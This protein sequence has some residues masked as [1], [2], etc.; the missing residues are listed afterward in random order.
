MGKYI[1]LDVHAT[2]CTLAVIGAQGR[3][4]GE[5][6]QSRPQEQAPSGG[7]VKDVNGPRRP[8]L[9]AGPTRLSSRS[10]RT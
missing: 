1:G 3:K 9:D 5:H 2:S 10:R 7:H 8:H 4:L 6:V